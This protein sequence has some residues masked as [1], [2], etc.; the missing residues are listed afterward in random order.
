[1]KAP[2][3]FPPKMKDPG[4]FIIA[5]TI[6]EAKIPHALC[7]LESSINVIPLKKWKELKI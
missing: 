6:G 7:D 3:A 2:Q 1:M 4:K 5:C